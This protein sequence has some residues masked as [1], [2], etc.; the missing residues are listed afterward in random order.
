MSEPA[1]SL[2]SE[3]PEH[4]YEQWH[5]AAEALLKGAPF[6][7][8]LVS[9]TYEDITIQPIYRRED[10]ASL[11]Q[12]KDFPGAA[13]L[14]RGSH[15]EGFLKAGW[16]VSQELKASSTTELN[17]MIHEGLNGGQSELS[18]AVSCGQAECC[19]VGVALHTVDD[20]RDSAK[21]NSLFTS[22]S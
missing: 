21:I 4:T 7:K 9:K 19:K 11:A 16:E 20:L 3:F 15:A 8:L 2:L 22:D 13:S 6:E 10:I 18:I 5:A 12:R 14:V 17:A 1:T